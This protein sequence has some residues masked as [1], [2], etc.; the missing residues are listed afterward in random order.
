MSNAV[1][2]LQQVNKTYGRGAAITQAVR[3]VSLSVQRGSWVAIVG[4]SGHGKSTLLQL[5]GGLDR[6]DSGRILLHGDDL[7]TLGASQLAAVRAKR[8]GFVFQF[9]NLLPHLTALENI[10]TAL[11][12]GGAKHTRRRANAL[13]ER[14]G[15]AD[16]AQHLPDMLSGGQQQRVAMARALANEPDILLMDEP[17]GNLDSTAEADLL[18]LLTELHH[19]G[20]TLLMV[21]HNPLVAQ[22]AERV[23]HVKD[24][25][26]IA[27]TSH[28]QV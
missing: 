20:K 25:K 11:W 10:E 14:F 2:A 17:T 26:I 22:R 6:P 9:F 27:D 28:A 13:L 12:M 15:L 18:T 5:M 7:A 24:G 19:E 8:I 21:T 4:P 3:D 16:K 23:L 1:I